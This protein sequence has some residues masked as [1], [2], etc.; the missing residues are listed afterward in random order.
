M[1]TSPAYAHIG[2]EE[3]AEIAAITNELTTGMETKIK[4][5]ELRLLVI[6]TQSNFHQIPT[7]WRY[8]ADY[9]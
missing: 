3:F 7:N 6:L 5:S 2:Q 4:T 8:F 1:A 9:H